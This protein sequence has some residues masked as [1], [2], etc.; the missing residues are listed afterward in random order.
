LGYISR[1]AKEVRNL[2]PINDPHKL[3]LMR[4]AQQLVIQ[5]AGR[6]APS[7]CC[8]LAMG[9]GGVLLA[10]GPYGEHTESLL[11]VDVTPLPPVARGTEFAAALH[12]RGYRGP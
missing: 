8:S 9:P 7:A 5:G 12:A 1:Q 10:E 2:Q 11:C 3:A 4:C 6:A